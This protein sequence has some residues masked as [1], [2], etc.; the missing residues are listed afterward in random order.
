[1]TDNNMETG[2][3]AG[4]Q[5]TPNPDGS[6]AAGTAPSAVDVKALAEALR[7]IVAEEVERRGQSVKDKRFAKI[8]ATQDELLDRFND[9]LA[10]GKSPKEAKREIALDQLLAKTFAEDNDDTLPARAAGI[11]TQAASVDTAAWLSSIGLTDK[12]PDVVA[13]YKDY[14]DEPGEFA[15]QLLNITAKRQQIQQRPANVAQVMSAGG[16]TGVPNELEAKTARLE[17]LIKNPTLNR[18]E[19]EKLQAE[20]EKLIKAS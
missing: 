1:M 8:E 7:P 18:A 11:R 3:Q 13:A 16:G 19:I 4:G 17:I 10:S 12:D 9:L 6:S 20:L 15:Q 5:G 14:G 2:Q